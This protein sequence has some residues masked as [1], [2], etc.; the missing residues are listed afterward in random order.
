MT[1][2]CMYAIQTAPGYAPDELVDGVLRGLLSNLH[3]GICELLDSL[4]RYLTMPNASI[5]GV[6]EVLYGIQVWST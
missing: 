5:H 2:T 3:Q 6:P 4:W 1:P